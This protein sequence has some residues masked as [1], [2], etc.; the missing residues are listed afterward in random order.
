MTASGFGLFGVWN[1]TGSERH[2]HWSREER[3]EDIARH[4]ENVPPSP[5]NLPRPL[6][7]SHR[8]HLG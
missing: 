1:K 6:T 5:R 2:D 4:A 3:D 7:P 8:L